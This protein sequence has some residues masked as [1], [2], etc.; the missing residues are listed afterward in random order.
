MD[1]TI[2]AHLYVLNGP[3]S[4]PGIPVGSLVFQQFLAVPHRSSAAPHVFERHAG[5]VEHHEIVRPKPFHKMKFLQRLFIPSGLSE[6]DSQFHA[7]D[8]IRVSRSLPLELPVHKILHRPFRV[9]ALIQELI[10]LIDDRHYNVIFPGQVLCS[11]GCSDTFR[12]GL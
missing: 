6:Q 8:G 3:L 12:N 2:S 10:D 5:A 4:V 1:A 9:L 11:P 7:G